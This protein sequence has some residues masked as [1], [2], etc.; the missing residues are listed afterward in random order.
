LPHSNTYAVVINVTSNSPKQQY[1]RVV[2][3]ACALARTLERGQAEAPMAQLFEQLQAQD[4][5][6]EL[7]AVVLPLTPRALRAML[8]WLTGP[9]LVT[10]LSTAV[11]ALG[12]VELALGGASTWVIDAGPRQYQSFENEQAFAQALIQ[13][14]P[15]CGL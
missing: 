8:T 14:C 7:I 11:E 2:D 13:T 5:K 10:S 6:S 9:E 1:T 3:E 4:S 12:S 15:P